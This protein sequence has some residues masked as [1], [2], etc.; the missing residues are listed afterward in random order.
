[1]GTLCQTPE[2][3]LEGPDSWD[4]RY[5]EPRDLRDAL[6]ER[7]RAWWDGDPALE[8]PTARLPAAGAQ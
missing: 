1:M 5:G 4:G 6:E 7:D 2:V 3:P 8:W